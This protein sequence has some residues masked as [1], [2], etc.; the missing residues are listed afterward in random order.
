MW[1]HH[2]RSSLSRYNVLWTIFF[3]MALPAHSGPRPLIQFRNQFTQT[4]GLLGRVISP[5]QHLYLN[6]GQHKYRINAYTH[7]TS[8]PWVGFE[9]T[10]PAS[11]QAKTVHALDQCFSTAGA[12]ARYGAPVMYKKNLP[13][14]GLTKVENHCLRPRDYSDRLAWWMKAAP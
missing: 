13:G 4:V 7:Q 1:T 5:S 11:E 3:P 10:I 12:A 9:A 8:M 2:F 6:I 14:R